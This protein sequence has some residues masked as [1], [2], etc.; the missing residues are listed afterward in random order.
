MVPERSRVRVPP[1]GAPCPRLGR[2]WWQLQLGGQDVGVGADKHNLTVVSPPPP[3]SASTPSGSRAPS[4]GT[5]GLFLFFRGRTYQ[6]H[7]LGLKLY[8]AIFLP[9]FP[10]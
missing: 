9:L 5:D 7:S 8:H 4:L 6:T 2:M 10:A 1:T 3:A